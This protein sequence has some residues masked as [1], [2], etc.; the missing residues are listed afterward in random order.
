MNKTESEI[1]NTIEYD[2]RSYPL[3]NTIVASTEVRLKGL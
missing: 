1:G 3:K 2:V